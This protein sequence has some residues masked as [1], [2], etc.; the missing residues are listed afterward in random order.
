MSTLLFIIIRNH[1]HIKYAF[2]SAN[3]LQGQLQADRNLLQQQAAPNTIK[4]SVGSPEVQDKGTQ[5]YFPS[6]SPFS[7][8]CFP[9]V[10]SFIPPLLLYI[11]FLSDN[12]HSISFPLSSVSFHTFSVLFCFFFCFLL[13]PLLLHLLLS[14][15]ST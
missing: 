13:L 1:I 4:F 10:N 14:S 3:E 12:F 5:Y 7:L 11:L 2:F 9:F 6:L 15:L 8:Y